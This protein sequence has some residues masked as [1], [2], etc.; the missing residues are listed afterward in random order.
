MNLQVTDLIDV[1]VLQKIQDSFSAMTGMAALTTDAEGRPVTEGSHF[2]DYCMCYTRNSEIGNRRCQECDR[3][4]AELAMKKGCAT[5]YVCHSGLIDF[6]APIVA[7]GQVIGCFIGGQVLTEPPEKEK[8]R[9]IAQEIGV[10]FDPYWEAICKVPV[11]AQERIHAAADFLYTVADILSDMAYSKYEALLAREE[12]EQASNM[13]SDFLASMS[14]EIRTPMNAVLGMVEMALREDLPPAAKNYITQI[15]S[16]SKILLN[17][18]NDILDFSKIESGKMDIIPEEYEILSICEDVA[19]IVETRLKDKRVELLMSIQPGIPK[20]L[21]GDS[22]RV[23]Q[24]LINLANNAVKFTQKGKIEIVVEYEKIDDTKIRLK[25]RVE[26]TGC[27]MKEEDLGRIFDSFQQVDSKRNRNAEGTGLGLAICKKLLDL[28]DGRIMVS[29]EYEKGSVFSVELPQKVTDWEP[30]IE[31][32][33]MEQ[34]VAVGYFRN[35]HLAKHFFRS[36]R[37]LGVFSIA[38]IAPDRVAWGLE[39]YQQEIAGKRLFLFTE[40]QDV[41]EEFRQIPEQFPDMTIVE[42]VPFFSNKKTESDRW[43]IIRKPLSEQVIAMALAGKEMRLNEEGAETG[44]IDFIAP[45]AKVLIVDDN[46]INLTVTKGLL[47]PLRMKIYTVTSGIEAL[48]LIEQ[49]KFDLIFM[50]HMMPEM[51]GIEATRIIRRLHP[52]YAD[53]PIIALTAN[54]MDGMKETF[55]AEGM[56]D[57]VGKPIEVRMLIQKVKQWLPKEKILKY[58]TIIGKEEIAKE[59][60]KIVIGDLDTDSARRMLGDDKVFYSVLKEYYKNIPKKIKLIAQYKQ[61]NNL[62]AYTI[63]VHALK[64]TSRQI[65]ATRLA[66]LAAELERAGNDADLDTIREQTG[67]LL[68]MYEAYQE[69]LRP[70]CEEKKKATP[71]VSVDS[72]KLRSLFEKMEEAIDNLDIDEMEKVVQ[73]LQRYTYEAQQQELF[74]QLCETVDNIDVDGAME[75]LQKWNKLL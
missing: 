9:V 55:I 13:K 28:M 20:V 15:R 61:Q 3:Y 72:E 18:I 45:E 31:V 36:V 66:N 14:H 24:I 21:Y 44:E 32:P 65:G 19:N 7:D 53:V 46:E 59:P 38:M 29:S 34:V 67:E 68:T 33:D 17:I 58:R 52:D 4:G 47:E 35:R 22:V 64:S 30:S 50:D 42:L 74:E 11:M 26:D 27:G 10:P 51:D 75:I 71:K 25:M 56:N 63:E 40:E 49:E 5:T 43:R 12:M 57:F 41:D 1:S 54:V 70:F 62:I 16:S 60:E 2:T 8:I 39:A 23:R 69:V 37:Q 48:D 6:A 73:Q